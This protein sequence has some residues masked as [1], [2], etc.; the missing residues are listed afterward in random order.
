MLFVVVGSI[1]CSIISLPFIKN[2]IGIMSLMP[3]GGND[4]K[5]FDSHNSNIRL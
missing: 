5:T 3:I 2:Q 1:L 4:K